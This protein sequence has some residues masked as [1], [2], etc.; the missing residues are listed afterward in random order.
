MLKMDTRTEFPCDQSSFTRTNQIINRIV[1]ANA[2][3]FQ[4][5]NEEIITGI[6]RVG[7]AILLRANP[8]RN[9]DTLR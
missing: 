4:I 3:S 7:C 8:F 6:V 5:I 9:N 1:M 2:C